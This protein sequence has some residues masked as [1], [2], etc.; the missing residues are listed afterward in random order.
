M[1]KVKRADSFF[2]EEFNETMGCL[3]F[4]EQLFLDNLLVPAGWL[5][6]IELETGQNDSFLVEMVVLM[7]D[8]AWS[9]GSVITLIV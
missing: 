6:S 1:L 8:D 3:A 7:S 9:F 4:D 5:A 2:S